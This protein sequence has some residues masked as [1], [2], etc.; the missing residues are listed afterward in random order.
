MQQ[1]E[2]RIKSLLS[3]N[4]EN[5]LFIWL[6]KPNKFNHM[7]IGDVA[8][9]THKKH[10]YVVIGCDKKYYKAHRLAWFFTYGVWP[11]IDIDHINSVKH[12]NR[13][14][15]LRLAT[16]EQNCQNERKAR[17]NN[18]TG[19]LGVHYKDGWYRARL[20]V[21]GKEKYLGQ[22]KTSKEAYECYLKAK[23]QHHP[24]FTL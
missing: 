14:A 9:T 13:L 22:F 2:V 7:E 23:R 3:Y 6:K 5:G 24:F 11:E 8:G 18:K 4:P 12:D 1:F 17:S 10:G 21:N 16:R 19:L 15:N 20:H